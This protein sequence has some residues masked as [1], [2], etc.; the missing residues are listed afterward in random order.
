M[1]CAICDKEIKSK[2]F[3]EITTWNAIMIRPVCPGCLKGMERMGL[4]G[5]VIDEDITWDAQ[6]D[7]VGDVVGE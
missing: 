4:N 6:D 7:V 3:Y 2:Q 5:A 1:K